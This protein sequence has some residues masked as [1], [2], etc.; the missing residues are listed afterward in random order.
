MVMI[1]L[2]VKTNFE[3]DGKELKYNNDD[4]KCVLSENEL[5]KNTYICIDND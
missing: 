4:L 5:F 3:Y 2:S 1:L